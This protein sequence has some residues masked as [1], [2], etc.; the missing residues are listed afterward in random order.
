[1]STLEGSHNRIQRVP[2]LSGY[3]GLRVVNFSANILTGIVRMNLNNNSL[4]S[5]SGLFSGAQVGSDTFRCDLTEFLLRG[6][7]MQSLDEDV[8]RCLSKRTLLDV[9]MND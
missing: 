6:N 5:L 3:G 2:D 7:G 9:A 1:M 4:T 8:V